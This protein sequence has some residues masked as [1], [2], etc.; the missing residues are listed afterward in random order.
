MRQQYAEGEL[1]GILDKYPG[2]GSIK[3]SFL[4]TSGFE[5]SNFYIKTDTGEYVL[6]VFEG[7][8]VGDANIKFEV[9]VM[10]ACVQAGVKT[11]KVYRNNQGNLVSSFGS[12]SAIVMD[13]I[14]GENKDG[15]EISDE[16]AGQ[17][18][19]ETGK[20]DAALSM[21]SNSSFT[22]QNYEFDL[23]NFLTLKP[24]I[25][26]LPSEYDRTLI[27]SIFDRFEEIKP[28][29]D[30]LPKGIIHN[31][32]ALHNILVKGDTLEAII[33]FSDIAFSPYIQEIAVMGC[34]FFHDHNWKPHQLSIFI[35]GYKKS[36]RVS[37]LE[38]S[39]LYDL[40]LARYCVD[41]VEFNH[42][43]F[44]YGMD[45]Q[46][47]RQMEKNYKSLQRVRAF[48]KEKFDTL[49]AQE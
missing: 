11:P 9:D 32:V 42:W 44:Q 18:G 12:K 22:R 34:D 35:E 21:F 15:K 31:D 2:K 41:V 30:T 4:F 47:V 7:I 28:M 8:G 16:I 48:G 27:T 20:M 26:E 25:A 24:K 39:L 3:R 10:D 36:R 37:D 40:L 33:D 49:A 1:Q 14:D 13:F 6:K 38:L 23:K 43:N 19:E 5:N 17:L 29:F 45:N 46:R